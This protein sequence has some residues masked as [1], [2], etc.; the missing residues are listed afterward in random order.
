MVSTQ[1]GQW[2]GRKKVKTMVEEN[3][4]VPCEHYDCFANRST[5]YCN[6]LINNDFGNRAC[7]FYKNAKKYDQEEY[8]RTGILNR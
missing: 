3:I 4:T 1:E 7:P 6:C 8:D 5:G 2:T